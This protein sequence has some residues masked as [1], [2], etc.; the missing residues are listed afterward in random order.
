MNVIVESLGDPIWQIGG[1]ILLLATLVLLLAV[2]SPEIHLSPWHQWLWTRITLL[3]CFSL[4]LVLSA[5]VVLFHEANAAST[6]VPEAT[7][8]ASATAVPRGSSSSTS[9]SMASPTPTPFPRLVPRPS[10][11]LTT[12]CY[13]IDRQDLNTAWAQYAQALQRERTAPPPFLVRITIVHCRVDD[14]SDTS[15]TGLLLLKTIGPNGYGNDYERDFQFTL[16]VED[17]AWKIAQIARCFADGC[18]PDTTSIVP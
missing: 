7:Q 18:L 6:V 11:V 17:G 1:G 9:T 4:F 15:A 16:S 3:V 5:G 12:F 14:V 10:Q 2:R 8:P 13:A